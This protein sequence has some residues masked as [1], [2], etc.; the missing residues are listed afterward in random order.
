[1]VAL[2]VR[3]MKGKIF[4]IGILLFCS[5]LVSSIPY[6]NNLK[7]EAINS[8]S[9]V[10]VIFNEEAYLKNERI[11]IS[12]NLL[13]ISDLYE[14]DIRIK[15]DERQ[16]MPQKQGS[17]YFC[18]NALAI[19]EEDPIINDYVDE[20][21][22][23]LKLIKNK[24]I[25]TG[26][27]VSGKNN[28]ATVYLVSSLKIENIFNLFNET[29]I[30][31]TLYN[32][33]KEQIPIEIN[34]SEKLKYNWANVNY[35]MEVYSKIISF[36][37]DI[38][39][40][41]R[42][43]EEYNLTIDHDIN[44]LIVGDYNVMLI[45]YDQTNGEI[46]KESKKVRVV[47]KTPPTITTIFSD[48]I[49]INDVD[50]LTY[51]FFQDFTLE[52]NYDL[53]PTLQYIFYDAG[54]QALQTEAEFKMALTHQAMGKMSVWAVDT[55]NNI[56]E[57]HEILIEIVDTTAPVI[58]CESIISVDIMKISTFAIEDY[59]TITD[60]Y[61]LSP[62]YSLAFYN[63]K[64]ESVFN[65]E[66]AIANSQKFSVKILAFDSSGNYSLETT[67]VFNIMDTTAPNI[68]AQDL[69]IQDKEIES[70]N[71]LDHFVINDNYSESI[72]ILIKV[73]N[74]DGSLITSIQRNHNLEFRTILND[75]QHFK[76]IIEAEDLA[77]NKASSALLTI[78]VNDT[79][80]P[81]IEVFNLQNNQKY[82]FLKTIEYSVTDIYDLTPKVEIL[83]NGKA[84]LDE[85]INE[86]GTYQLTI[87]ATDASMN[88]I[89]KKITFIIESNVNNE[90]P[91][92]SN[93]LSRKHTI[94]VILGLL[95][96][97]LVILIIRIAN[98]YK[99][100]RQKNQNI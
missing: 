96:I 10:E 85:E 12:F 38:V 32:T 3:R 93:L 64:N 52:D 90:Q 30:F 71:F 84:Y 42:T 13:N 70:F 28:L 67:I 24:N 15:I 65:F 1:M 6:L 45:I 37:N 53:A 59:V 43:E 14:A 29:N 95:L 82:S 23:R 66:E 89:E 97:S 54:G 87:T 8:D 72:F 31:V 16:V 44:P 35:E 51:D 60:N 75:Y 88:K 7:V 86:I 63:E 74:E 77:Q 62:G 78:N 25:D 19:F 40:T 98:F 17:N 57:K 61:D 99:I 48:K 2:E 81:Q 79:T 100:K 11:Q 49:V 73:L 33:K 91:T 20:T 47:D 34:F 83:L 21:Y 46:I 68:I 39:V 58:N 50:V 27:N 92:I 18:L 26:Y 9:R 55:S 5:V 41:N 76:I 36:Q 56:S 22:L 4:K 69:T 94:Y 80:P